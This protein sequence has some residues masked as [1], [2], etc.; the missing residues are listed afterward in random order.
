MDL[1]VRDSAQ[2]L[3]VSEKTIY[4]WVKQGKLPAYRIHEQYRFNRAELLEWATSQRLNV[5]ADI[6]AEPD[7]DGPIVTLTDALR[8]GGIHYRLGGLDKPSALKALVDIMPLPDEV[9]RQFLYQV[10][11][12]RESLGSTAL[13][14]GI[15]VPHV[16]NPIVLHIVRP[17][18]TLC[19]LEQP[20]EFGALDGQ[21]VHTLF[22]I[23]SPT[24]R[25]HL[26]LLSRL[27][28]ALRQPVFMEAIAGQQS[29]ERI[30]A[31][32]QAVDQSIPASDTHSPINSSRHDHG[33]PPPPPTVA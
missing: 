29:R 31:A 19:F 22:T 1:S 25:A 8:A 13:G 12:A 20:I 23:V 3:K 21:P 5:S 24:V 27:G 4:R 10:L 26:H 9:D 16:R 2:L 14:S 15:A 11:L 32:S 7:G 28:F 30:F 33:D 17:M 18:I 6:F